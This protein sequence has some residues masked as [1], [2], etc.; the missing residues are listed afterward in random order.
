MKIYLRLEA[1]Y[2]WARVNGNSV[3]A[4]GEVNALAE[5]PI[6]D[7]EEVIGVVPGQFVTTHRISLPAK[8]KKQFNQALPYALE[9]SISEGVDNIHFICPKWKPADEVTVLCVAKERMRSWQSMATEN[10]LPIAQL[11][12]DYALLPFHEAAEGSICLSESGFIASHQNF[13]GVSIDPD[14]IDLWIMDIPLTTTIAVNNED[15]TQS[16]IENHDNRDFRYWQFG[17]KMRHWL[18]YGFDSN[19][20]LWGD[21]FRPKVRRGGNRPFL[22]PLVLMSF[23]LI[24]ILA[25]D[26]HRYVALKSEI[27]ELEN[28]MS[29]SLVDAIPD[30]TGVSGGAARDFMEKVLQRGQNGQEASSVHSTL[31]TASSVLGRMKATLL[32]MNYQNQELVLTCVLTDFSQVDVLTKQFNSRKSLVA[33]LQ[34]SS[35]ED[36]KV[37]ATYSVR[38][39]GV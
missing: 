4:F 18:E 28:R 21:T 23:A 39:K 24:T 27:N 19:I 9:D 31:A 33:S 11:L 25:Y 1:P 29:D 16:L 6:C 10:R 2:E 3:E 34:G 35:A 12:P 22:L 30:A 38:R 15:L 36:G 14:L 26:L 20:D 17:D 37:I 13:G 5:Y 7:N 32:E 8:T